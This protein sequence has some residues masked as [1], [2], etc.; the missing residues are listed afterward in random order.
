M[1]NIGLMSCKGSG[2][3]FIE[4]EDGFNNE[5]IAQLKSTDQTHYDLHQDDLE[6]LKY[7]ASIDHKKPLFLIEYLQWTELWFVCLRENIVEIVVSMFRAEVLAELKR[8]EKFCD[9]V[10]KVP[11]HNMLDIDDMNDEIEWEPP[12][13]VAHGNA[14]QTAKERE[15]RWQK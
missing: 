14:Q 2:N 10:V 11:Q 8:T 3:G 15:R 4:K 9:D 6:I 5:V 7:H 1:A 13:A 12:Q